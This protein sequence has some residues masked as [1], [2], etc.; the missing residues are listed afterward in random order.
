[1]DMPGP[2]VSQPLS[3]IPSDSE[4]RTQLSRVLQSRAFRKSERLCRFLEFA[5]RCAI[6]RTTD[7]LKESVLGR[8]VFDRGSA[9]DPRTD[10]IVRVESQ[11]LRQ[12]LRDYYQSEGSGDPVSIEFKPGSYVPAFRYLRA[13]FSA[14]KGL[15]PAPVNTLSPQTVAVLPLRNQSSDP[16]VYFCDGITEELIYALSRIEGL[17]VIGLTSVL[18]LKNESLDARETGIRL[19]AGTIISGSVRK[20]DLQLKI[21]VEILNAETGQVLWVGKFDRQTVE[22]VFAVEEEIAQSVARTLQVTL[23]PSISRQIIR[24]APNMDAYLL[25]LKGRHYWNQMSVAGYRQAIGAFEEAIS[26]YAS[27]A[28]PYAGLADA[29]AY[30]AL[31]G[32]ARP[33]DV[34]PK[35]RSSA[36]QALR[37][38]PH[39][40]HAFSA[41]AATTSFYDWKWDEGLALSRRALELEPSYSFGQHIRGCCLLVGGQDDDAIACLRRAISLDPLSVRAH[42]TLGWAFYLQRR[43]ESAKKWLEGALTLDPQSVQ[44]HYLL[45]HVHI[46]QR[47]YSAA[48]EEARLCQITPQDPLGLGV[49]GACLAYLGKREEASQILA[50]LAEL[51]RSEYVDAHALGQAQIALGDTRAALDSVGRSIEEQTPLAAFMQRDPEFDPLRS[52]SRFGELISR[53]GL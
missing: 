2:A 17:S 44:T 22:D 41:L 24:A 33:H 49:L 13:D 45:A 53:L 32:G 43:P 20:S 51:A 48:L 30:L 14:A 47:H 4:V 42:R 29:Y 7:Q 35:A 50:R 6:E 9:Y 3:G 21:H 28:S 12:R 19:G 26:L 16:E 5:V 39:L 18:A 15:E 11:R 8:A 38:D 46:C 10:S 25:Y 31:W 52:N 40:P 27:Y 1:M 34:F 36:M 23:A 37:L